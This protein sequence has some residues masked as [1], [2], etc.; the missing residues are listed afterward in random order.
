MIA[1][2][3]E[4]LSPQQVAQFAASLDGADWQ[5]GRLSS[6]PEAA[7]VKANSQVS[8]SCPIGRDLG[9][10]ILAVLEQ[11]PVFL[12]AALPRHLF[13]PQFNRYENGMAFGRHIDN[14]IR[15]L[16]GTPYRIRTDL[17]A[18]L[19]LSAPDSYQGGELV[20]ED[21][22]AT[23]SF[24]LDAGDMLLYPSGMRHQVLPVSS[25]TRLAA[26]FWVQSLI[27]DDSARGILYDLD[28]AIQ[29][30]SAEP[31][32]T[33]AREDAIATLTSSYHRLIKRW[34]EM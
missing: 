16:P 10:I 1:H 26:F 3:K 9:Q 15:T 2:L 12:S 22:D 33:P 30:L 34:A 29:N 18:T 17:S 14:A 5:D 11:N 28:Q 4:V 13:P 8:T 32:R 6:G 31:E 7:R 21:G 25:G 19:F 24:K 27:K 20:I 23:Q